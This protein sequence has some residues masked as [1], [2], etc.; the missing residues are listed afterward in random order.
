MTNVIKGE[1]PKEGMQ[2]TKE[3]NQNTQSDKLSAIKSS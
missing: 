2:K 1:G 3:V